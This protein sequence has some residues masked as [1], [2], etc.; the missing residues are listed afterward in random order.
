MSN[1]NPVF[2]KDPI[3]QKLEIQRLKA[4]D[5]VSRGMMLAL[6]AMQ[7]QEKRIIELSE[8]P[9][10]PEPEE[11]EQEQVEVPPRPEEREQN[12]VEGFILMNA[13]QGL[14]TNKFNPLSDGEVVDVALLNARTYNIQ[15]LTYPEKVQGIVKVQI[16]SF[17]T[18]YK[19]QIES[20]PP[21]FAFGK[22]APEQAMVQAE[23]PLGEY[24][25]TAT[26]MSA[27]G[28]DAKVLHTKSISF[29]VVDGKLEVRKP[30]SLMGDPNFDASKLPSAAQVQ[31]ARV[32]Q[33]IKN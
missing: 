19:P 31:H 30:M 23:L 1:D 8:V 18:V 28:K 16:E 17:G 3:W 7:A 4:Q 6:V 11:S 33:T 13:S 15:V 22:V 10:E 12:T 25:L 20:A 14:P 32:K 29:S 2:S 27:K 5:M 26:I 9:D 21:Y 24:G